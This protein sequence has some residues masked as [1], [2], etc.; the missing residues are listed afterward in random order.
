[1]NGDNDIVQRLDMLIA[2]TRLA[3]ADRIEEARTEIR[4]DKANETILDAT[5]DWVQAG[6]LKT[7]AI[8][9]SKQSK[10]TIERRIA[11]L[12]DGGFLS[13]RGSSTSIEYRNTGLI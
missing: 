1:M 8:Q 7:L 9:K 3:N 13:K 2:I 11:A 4:M 12:V 10:P 5:S 6:K